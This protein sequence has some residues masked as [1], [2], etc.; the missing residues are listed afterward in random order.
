MTPEEQAV[1]EAAKA[2]VAAHLE[3]FPRGPIRRSEAD[4]LFAVRSLLT[5]EQEGE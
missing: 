5:K 1:I 3:W 2:W 4:L